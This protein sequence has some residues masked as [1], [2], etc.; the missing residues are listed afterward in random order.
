MKKNYTIKGILALML[1]TFISNTTNAQIRIVEVDPAAE[2]VKI[3]NYGGSTVNIANYR[4]CSLIAYRTL[5]SQTT[6]QSGSLNL[7]PNQ[8][9]V[10]SIN[11]GGYLNDTAADLG[12]Y[13]ATG[14]FGDA[15]RMVDFMQWGSGG[16]GRESV[17]VTKGIWTAGTFVNVS[18]PYEYTGNG[19]QNGASFWD[20]LLGIDDFENSSSFSVYP[21]PTDSMLNIQLKSGI[22]NGN[23]EVFDILGKLVLSQG[24]NSENLSEINVAHLN[25]GLYL[26][27]IS[28]EDKSETQR[29]IKN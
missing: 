10:V 24:L 25:S 28:A 3:H 4:L 18:P 11:G 6:V 27:K 26:I 14:S 9:V 12:L 29:F 17:A 23:L 21:N 15:T 1:I 8:D 7:G 16:N 20:T 22:S 13:L 19:G 2:T 5:S